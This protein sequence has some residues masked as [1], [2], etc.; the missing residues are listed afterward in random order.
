MD[1]DVYYAGAA[2]RFSNIPTRVYPR[3][4]TFRPRGITFD[5]DGNEVDNGQ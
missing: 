4:V 2:A 1:T 3:T 5:G